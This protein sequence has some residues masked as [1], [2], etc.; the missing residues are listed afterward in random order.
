MV[1]GKINLKNLISQLFFI[2]SPII[3]FLIALFNINSEKSRKNFYIIS[4]FF[5]SLFILKN[6]P[7]HDV[8]RYYDRFN[9]IKSLNDVGYY[10][11]D[12]FFD[13]V[14]LFFNSLDIPFYFL[15]PLFVFLTFYFSFKGV[16][17]IIRKY[18]FNNL[19][20]IFLILSIIVLVNPILVSL[21]LRSYLG[22]A[23]LFYSIVL[24]FFDNR[25][26]SYVYMFFSVITHASFL[27]FLI[28]FLLIYFYRPNKVSVIIL[29]LSIFIS[30]KFLLP[31]ILDFGLVGL[32]FGDL[33]GYS[34]FDNLENKSSRGVVF[35][36]I[37]IAIKLFFIYFCYSTVNLRNLNIKEK[38]LFFYIGYMILIFSASSISE[39]A[40]G[41]YTS[42][43]SFLIFFMICTYVYR[44][45]EYKIIYSALIIIIFT[46]N[47][48]ILN[49][50]I[51]RNV[52]LMGKSIEM[53]IVSPLNMVL[54]SKDEYD[55]Y[56]SN[57]GP[58][59]YPLNGPGS[60]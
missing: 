40:L 9:N 30:S 18:N 52:F 12:Y 1:T 58:D 41:R 17:L 57:I 32:I 29:S 50:Y 51:N 14:S 8:Y 34:Q 31:K 15:P 60:Q 59:G 10:T 24:Y 44:F 23:F 46:F 47:F 55:L 49:V 42:Y 13:F 45:R 2:L 21:G 5:F 28:P 4:S 19:F 53:S 22:F 16:E 38:Y 11:Q 25:K 37:T 48:L 20:N 26:K 43:T 56:L 54:Y 3:G 27:I 35:Y 39:V 33:V 7:I 36:Y 6:P